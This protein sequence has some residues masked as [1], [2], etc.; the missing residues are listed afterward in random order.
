MTFPAVG[1][2]LTV[3]A[4]LLSTFDRVRARLSTDEVACLIVSR[5]LA[6]VGL[7]RLGEIPRHEKVISR[8]SVHWQRGNGGT[9]PQGGSCLGTVESEQSSKG[10]RYRHKSRS[11]FYLA[12]D[13]LTTGSLSNI[14]NE[15]SL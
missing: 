8:V 14:I 2:Q 12:I 3:T 15:Q 11:E 5:R 6:A 13:A 4:R 9:G 10:D 7:H 1:S